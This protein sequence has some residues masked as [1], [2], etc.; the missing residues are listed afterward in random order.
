MQTGT[1]RELQ[2]D[3]TVRDL[4]GATRDL[5]E[6]FARLETRKWTVE[7][8]VMELLAEAGSLADSIVIREGYRP[9]RPGQ[10]PIDLE[11]DVSDVL[12]VLIM[13]ADKYGIDLGAAYLK[14]LNRTRLKL[15][16]KLQNL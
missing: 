3:L 14:M 6:L 16:Q 12:F 2:E 15:E 1:G 11:D 9:V 7:T 4:V 5:V 13:I 10:K 8:G